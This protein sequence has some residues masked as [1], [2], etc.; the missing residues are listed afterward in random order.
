VVVENNFIGYEA[1]T[2]EE[3]SRWCHLSGGIEEGVLALRFC[4]SDSTEGGTP[5]AVAQFW[6]GPRN[7][8]VIY[9]EYR[10]PPVM[11]QNFGYDRFPPA[12]NGW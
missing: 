5:G 12:A 9:L 3:E 7:V 1:I 6:C 10:G 8:G 11:A 4:F 2:G